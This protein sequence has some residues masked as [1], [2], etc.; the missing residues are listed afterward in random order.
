MNHP[1]RHPGC[2]SLVQSGYCQKHAHKA[3]DVRKD[4]DRKRKLDPILARNAAFRSSPE[5]QRLRK[6]K[7][8]YDPLCQDPHGIHKR[9]NDTESAVDIDH[10]EGL[11]EAWDKRADWDNLMSLCRRCHSIKEQAHRRRAKL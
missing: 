11:T 2:P 3:Q 9:V 7:L 6:R 5:W 4:Y 10:I 1:C 8:S